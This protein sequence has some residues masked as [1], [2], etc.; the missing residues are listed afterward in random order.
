MSTMRASIAR[1]CCD[2]EHDNDGAVSKGTRTKMVVLR[3]WDVTRTRTQTQT[4]H[5]SAAAAAL[6]SLTSVRPV[7]GLL[8]FER[9]TRRREE[10]KTGS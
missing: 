10:C 8:G 7:S 4:G 5:D 3:A 9:A 2:S 6:L 1:R